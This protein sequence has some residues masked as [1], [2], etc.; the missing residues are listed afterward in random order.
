[1]TDHTIH[2][3]SRCVEEE[4]HRESEW[5]KKTE[6]PKKGPSDTI[7]VSPECVGWGGST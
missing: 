4:E 3:Y 6:C 7:T 2:S 1:M 5:P